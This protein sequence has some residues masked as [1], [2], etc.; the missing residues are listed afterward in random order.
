LKSAAFQV[1]TVVDKGR[2]CYK[3]LVSSSPTNKLE[4]LSFTKIV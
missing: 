1:G 3:T 4:R 2:R